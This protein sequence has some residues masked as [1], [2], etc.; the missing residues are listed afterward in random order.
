MDFKHGKKIAGDFHGNFESS[1]EPKPWDVSNQKF[2]IHTIMN[3]MFMN[4]LNT[5]LDKISI[6]F[7]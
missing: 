2:L 6:V 5:Q 4:K 3:T 7:V 1:Q